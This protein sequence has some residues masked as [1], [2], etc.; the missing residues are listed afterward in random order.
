MAAAAGPAGGCRWET[1]FD[2]ALL[3]AARLASAGGR[4]GVAGLMVWRFQASRRLVPRCGNS[5]SP[6]RTANSTN[7]YEPRKDIKIMTKISTIHARE[8]LDSRGNPTLEA[9]VTLGRRQLRPRPGAFRRVHRHPRGG[10][11]ARR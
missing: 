4:G 10:R 5:G 7:Q 3:A 8:V 9:E 11:A 1:F 2:L 6:G